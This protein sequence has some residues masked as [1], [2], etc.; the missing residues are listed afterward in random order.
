MTL[1]DLRVYVAVCAAGSLSAVARDL[2]C[3]QSAVSQHIR[4]LEREVG[5]TLLERHAR[6]V[7]PTAAGRIL[8]SAAAEGIGG[9][10]VALRRLRDLA[11]GESGTVRVTTGATTVRHFMSEAIVGFRRRHPQVSLEFQTVSSSHS[12][13]EALAAHDLDLAWVTMGAPE[14]GIEQRPV[15]ELPWVLAVRADDPLAA[16]ERIEPDDLAAAHLIRPPEGSTSRALLDRNFAA[17]G[18]VRTDGPDAGVADWAT[19]VHLAEL[20][21]GHAVVP[22]LPGWRDPDRVGPALVPVPSLPPLA[23]GW[24]VR[25]WSTLTPVAKGFA[26]LVA[27]HCRAGG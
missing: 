10:D 19:A 6:G 2:A 1:D 27:E 21:L 24:A 4:R 15:A 25:R 20:G 12:A 9:I 13:Y 11:R 5:V 7:L 16:R 18:I 26:D 3:T 8:Q 14:R 22:E 23:V 17:L